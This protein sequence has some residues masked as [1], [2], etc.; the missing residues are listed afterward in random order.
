[1]FK[2]FWHFDFSNQNDSRLWEQF[3]PH[4]CPLCSLGGVCEEEVEDRV[5]GGGSDRGAFNKILSDRV[6]T[7]EQGS[8]KEIETKSKGGGGLF[9][10]WRFFFL[11]PSHESTS[12]SLNFCLNVRE[13]GHWEHSSKYLWKMSFLWTK[14]QIFELVKS[15]NQVGN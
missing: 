10:F 6:K 4:S 9:R 1:M 11:K 2:V 8:W 13:I 3:P 7:P 5:Y 14:L 15:F 12:Q